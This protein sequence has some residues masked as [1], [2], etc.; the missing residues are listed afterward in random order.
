MT[1]NQAILQKI[2][3]ETRF[4]LVPQTNPRPMPEDY[5]PYHQL[6]TFDEGIEDYM[7]GRYDNPYTDPRD[8]VKAQAW[9]RGSEYSMRVVRW[10]DQQ[11]LPD[12]AK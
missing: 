7:S 12:F 1:R 3:R 4:S 10:T 2:K 8:G 9:D 11:Y 6:P 5:T